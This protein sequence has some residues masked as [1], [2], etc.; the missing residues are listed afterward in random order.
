MPFLTLKT[1]KQKS[2]TAYNFA[3]SAEAPRKYMDKD[4]CK[5]KI[6]ISLKITKFYKISQPKNAMLSQ[7]KLCNF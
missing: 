6:E 1:F 5:K 7:V 4:W 2:K 3:E